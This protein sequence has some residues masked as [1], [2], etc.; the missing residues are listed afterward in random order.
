[1]CNAPHSCLHAIARD[2]GQASGRAGFGL[3]LFRFKILLF[4]LLLV[5]PKILPRER[6]VQRRNEALCCRDTRRKGPTLLWESSTSYS[7]ERR[8]KL[9]L[10]INYP[11]PFAYAKGAEIEKKYGTIPGCQ[12]KAWPDVD[13][14]MTQDDLESAYWT[15]LTRTK[16]RPPA[17]TSKSGFLHLQL[18]FNGVILD[19]PHRIQEILSHQCNRHDRG[20]VLSIYPVERRPESSPRISSPWLSSFEIGEHPRSKARTVSHL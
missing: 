7:S 17:S 15:V 5:I 3:E 11:T 16:L 13:T 4:V 1:M 8:M 2:P 14:R 12:R 19:F 10:I 18:Q 9:E 6:G 20:S